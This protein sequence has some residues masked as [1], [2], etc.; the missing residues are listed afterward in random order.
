MDY[1]TG[2]LLDASCQGDIRGV[3][4]ET[5]RTTAISDPELIER[6]QGPACPRERASER[7]VTPLTKISE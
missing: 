6:D 1:P 7:Y 5:D 2:V 3:Q 4:F